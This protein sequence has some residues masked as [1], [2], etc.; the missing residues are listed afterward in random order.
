MPRPR[1]KNRRHDRDHARPPARVDGRNRPR[2]RRS[3]ARL[4][5]ACTLI[6]LPGLMPGGCVRPAAPIFPLNPS[7]RAWPLPPD[8]PRI[9]YVGQLKSSADLKKPSTFLQRL[10]SLLVG[11]EEPAR[12]YGP[13]A[14]H[15]SADGSRV[16]IG[17]PGGRCLHLFNLEDRTYRR[18][19]DLD[20]IPLLSPID[21]CAGPPGSFYVC[22]S[23]NVAIHRLD[24][25]TGALIETLRLE[26]DIRR[27]VALTYDAER[28]VLFV[29]DV[30]AHNIKVLDR[31]GTIVQ[32]IGRRGVRGGEFNFP[33]DIAYDGELLWVADTGNH[34]IQSLTSRGEP[35]SRFGRAGDA[36]GD[37]SL[38]KRIA[39]DN[40][41]NI[42]IV[43][44]RFENVQ[45]FDAT[46]Q[47]LLFLGEEGS[48]PG[49]FSLPSSVV[50]DQRDRIWICDT[51]NRR[52]QVFDALSPPLEG[53][54][55]AP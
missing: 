4:G 52:I 2:H 17:D 7:D 43:D 46:G 5:F 18:F 34:R 47:L 19:N 22:D 10:G 21:F 49:Q 24:E 14:I 44:S 50:I 25:R 16:W 20:G 41:G 38:P 23:E 27:P 26:E 9:R 3:L 54:G 31:D 53:D 55:L 32:T 13:Q 36:L 11:S 28:E 48:G 29:V 37:M 15:C 51:Y 30:V 40:D 12:L 42:Y 1:H 8:A 45:I 35:V 6:A 39:L 33:C